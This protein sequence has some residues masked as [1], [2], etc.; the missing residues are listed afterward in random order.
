M[1]D[2]VMDII[3]WSVIT[4]LITYTENVFLFYNPHP[5][6][7]TL[8]NH[9]ERRLVKI[10]T[11]LCNAPQ[12]MYIIGIYFFASKEMENVCYY[13]EYLSKKTREKNQV[14]K[15]IRLKI[16]TLFYP[17]LLKHHNLWVKLLST[18][19]SHLKTK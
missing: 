6:F 3:T 10:I 13:K 14:G 12:G 4:S 19:L 15:Q 8:L 7:T 11:A 18:M 9:D 5:R 16:I 17:Y 1:L 2:F